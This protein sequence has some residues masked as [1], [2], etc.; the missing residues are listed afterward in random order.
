MTA[1]IL[2]MIVPIG[3]S[4]VSED[5]TKPKKTPQEVQLETTKDKPS[6]IE[7]IQIQQ[8]TIAQELKKIKN[9]LKKKKSN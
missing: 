5:T 6:C 7:K 1:L 8:R 3:S 4:T 9:I 2:M